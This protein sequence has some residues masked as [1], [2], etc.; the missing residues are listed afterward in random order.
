MANLTDNAIKKVVRNLLTHD[1]DYRVAIIATLNARFMDF[2]IGFFQDIV[3][4]KM[5]K[6]KIDADWY[7]A[8]FIDSPAE[9]SDIATN[10]GINLKT[11]GNIH[12]TQRREIVI[13]AA[14]DNY[15]AMKE[16]IDELIREGEGVDITMSIALNGVSVELTINESLV[17]INALA[18]KRAALSGGL[19]SS[20]GKRTE[21]VL[22]LTLCDLFSVDRK[23]Y[24]LDQQG[25]DDAEDVDREIDFFLVN[26][27]IRNKCEVKLIGKGNPE[28][29]DA[30]LAR[31]SRV[32]VADTMSE[33]NIKQ[34]NYRRVQWVHLK[35][36]E[37]YRRFGTVLENLNIP[38]KPYCGTLTK[39]IGGAIERA[40]AIKA[41]WRKERLSL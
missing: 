22:M 30:V 25:V 4:A 41:S 10:A 12:G 17:V 13:S 31:S 2:V 28:S 40:Y 19:W 9:K 5:K 39:D 6:E 14:N 33:K 18:V 29:A 15:E 7:K 35:A 3:R 38:H 32:Y 34:M 16:M 37:G 36:D 1:V 11:I 27:D 24:D 8:A 23:H 26:G 21:G 20:V